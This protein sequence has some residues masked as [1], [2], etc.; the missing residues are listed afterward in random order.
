MDEKDI[1]YER[2]LL[3]STND[4]NEIGVVRVRLY[5]TKRNK[6]IVAVVESKSEHNP[7]E[8]IESI[9]QSM[10]I[11]MFK[12]INVKISENVDVIVRYDNEY[13]KV[14]LSGEGAASFHFEGLKDF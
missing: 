9:L 1:V 4:P 5:S 6:K 11:E 7:K 14:I 12:R 8:Y 13:F 10:E 3:F 2:E